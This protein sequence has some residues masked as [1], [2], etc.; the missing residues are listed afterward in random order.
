[1]QK[2]TLL[3]DEKMNGEKVSSELF[4]SIKKSAENK[5]EQ[6]HKKNDGNGNAED[7]SKS[8]KGKG[9]DGKNNSEKGNNGKG[10]NDKNNSGKSNN[11]KGKSK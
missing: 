3:F 10:K 11:G 5:V 2:K 4:K 1:M 8:N 6:N 9:S 7:D